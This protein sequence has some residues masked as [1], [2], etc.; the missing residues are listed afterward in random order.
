MLWIIRFHEHFNPLPSCEGRPGR[1]R[2]PKGEAHFNPLPSC[3][4]RRGLWRSP[5]RCVRHFNPLPSCEGRLLW[6]KAARPDHPFQ[7][8]PLMRGET[9]L[10]LDVI[11]TETISIHSPHTRGDV[12]QVVHMHILIISIH[13]PHARGDALCGRRRFRRPYFNPL[14]SCEGRPTICR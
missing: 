7:S 8:T 10:R 2:P 9:R 3:E 6:R 11:Q 12:Q 14:P 1:V 13:S 5:R 4:G